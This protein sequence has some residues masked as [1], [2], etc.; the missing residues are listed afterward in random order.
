MGSEC[1]TTDK[2]D[3]ERRGLIPRY[4]GGPSAIY[5]FEMYCVLCVV[6]CS[7]PRGERRILRELNAKEGVCKI[8]GGPS[9]RVG[10]C[11][12]EATPTVGIISHNMP[13]IRLTS[14]LVKDIV[15]TCHGAPRVIGFPLRA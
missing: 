11:N 14:Q 4:V 7:R 8:T 6:C 2:Y 12:F 9:E 1:G 13:E 10:V 15:G 5:V 3:D